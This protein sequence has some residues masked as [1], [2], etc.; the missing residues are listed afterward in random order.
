VKITDSQII[1]NSERELIDNIT[2][3]L[4]WEA[5]EKIF[6]EK[7]HIAIQDDVEYKQGDIV[8]YENQVA[9]KLDFEVKVTLSVL[10]D[11]NGNHIAFNT[12]ADTSEADTSEAEEKA[13]TISPDEDINVE[14]DFVRD[15]ESDTAPSIDPDIGARENMSQMASELA[16]M[17][18]D[19]NK[20]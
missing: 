8:V 20:D 6:R 5:V 1:K 2:A 19:I 15:E 17:I 4:D 7:H 10:L 9:Y 12:S 14:A 11:R 18:T 16:D 13:D 3:D